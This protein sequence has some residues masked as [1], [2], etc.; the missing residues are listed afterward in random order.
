MFP[1]PTS[2]THNGF[3]TSPADGASVAAAAVSQAVHRSCMRTAEQDRLHYP[4]HV[5]LSSVGIHLNIPTSETAQRNAAT[6]GLKREGST[7]SSTESPGASILSS[8]NSRGGAPLLADVQ[9][10]DS[11]VTQRYSHAL[12]TSIDSEI[13]RHQ[14]KCNIQSLGDIDVRLESLNEYVYTRNIVS[15]H[16]I[17]K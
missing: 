2:H 10:T 4:A 15:Y 9:I 16:V 8:A 3:T 11:I 7:S 5:P 6:Y 14:E 12:P 17:E 13:Q 1:V